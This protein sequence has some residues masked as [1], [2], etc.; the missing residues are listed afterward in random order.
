MTADL[1]Y[2]QDELEDEPGH[3]HVILGLRA[4]VEF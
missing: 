3:E 1:Q 4:V 2:I